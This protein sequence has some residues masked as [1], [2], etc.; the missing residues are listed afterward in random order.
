MIAALSCAPAALHSAALVSKAGTV[1][2][3]HL[4]SEAATRAVLFGA[5]WWCAAHGEQMQQLTTGLPT[6]HTCSQTWQ[7]PHCGR[8]H[9]G[10][11]Y[12]QQLVLDNCLCAFTNTQKG[13]PW[14]LPDNRGPHTVCT[15]HHVHRYACGVRGARHSQSAVLCN[16]VFFASLSGL[17]AFRDAVQLACTTKLT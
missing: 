6:I 9:A 15:S 5:W 2:L 13:A 1:Y 12:S 7:V 4:Q 10:Q 3:Q 8:P 11:L 16:Q 17:G 14:G